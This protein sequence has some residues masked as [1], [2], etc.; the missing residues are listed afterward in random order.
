MFNAIAQPF[1]RILMFFYEQ[2]GS[3]V[4]ALTLIAT[5]VKVIL[6]PFQMKSKRGTMRQSRL[7]PKMEELKK[8]H[9][10]NKQKLNEEMAKLYKEE[11][12]NPASGCLWGILPLPIMIALFYA[13]RQPLTLMMGVKEELLNKGGQIYEKLISAG[14][15]DTPEALDEV[16]SGFYWQ[17]NIAQKISEFWSVFEPLG[18][19]HLR[20][21]SFNFGVMDMAEIPNWQFLWQTD[22]SSSAIWLPGLLIFLIPFVSAGSQ[23]V[24]TGITRK[25]NPTGSPEAAG[26]A[27]GGMLKLMP[28][29]SLW[30]GFMFPAALGFYWTVGTVLQI[31]QDVWLTKKYTKILDAE[32]E[33]KSKIR[34]EKEAEIEAK[35]LETERLKLEGGVERNRNT[36]KR[37][38]QKSDKQE[39]LEKAVE[40]EKKNAPPEEEKSKH[41]PGRIGNRR[42]ARGRA[43]DPDRYANTGQDG[44]EG[45]VPGIEGAEPVDHDI[46]EPADTEYTA[47]EF[48]DDFDD[49]VEDELDEDE[50]DEDELDEDDDEFDEDDYDDDEDD[51]YDEDDY[52]DSGDDTQSADQ[53][54]NTR[55]DSDD[56]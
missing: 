39:Q 37:K 24:A 42:Y 20:F 16:M 19:E 12:V 33:V 56:K 36:S 7:N 50:L 30:F 29:M 2:T 55:S 35:R 54:G 43:Y 51:D 28:L 13:I 34:K 11:G 53:S 15:Y 41:E 44:G 48:D 27:A 31:G 22:W 46:T 18:I 4:L 10:A 26:G 3:Y 6:L 8:R 32:D 40:W 45:F 5:L 49:E 23:F 1:G 52:D 17:V 14:A 47:A 25:M 38:K 9:G 21:I